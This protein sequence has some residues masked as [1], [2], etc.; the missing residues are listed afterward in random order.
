VT[1]T[2]PAGWQ[3]VGTT[4]STRTTSTVWQRVATSGDAGSTVSVDYSALAKSTLSLFAYSGT[5]ATSPVAAWQGVGETTAQ[6]A[7]TTPTVPVAASGSWALSYWADNS[8]ATTGWTLPGDVTSRGTVCGTGGGHVCAVAADSGGP[9][10]ST[11][12]GGLTATA[13]S[14]SGKAVMWTLVL[15]TS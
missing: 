1:P 15:Q 11:S 8:S 5:S 14:A 2:S 6:A 10:S 12:Y 3:L 13:D 4:T 7:H 9:V